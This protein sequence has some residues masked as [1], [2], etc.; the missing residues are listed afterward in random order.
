[1]KSAHTP[2]PWKVFY[3]PA[4][5]DAD[6]EHHFALVANKNK[7]TIAENYSNARLMAAAPDLLEALQT[8]VANASSV[9]LDPQ[10]A[11]QVARN[12]IAKVTGEMK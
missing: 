8:I 7:S 6:G 12:V 3:M 2:A 9:Q 1:M 5:S 10:W 4:S 11:V